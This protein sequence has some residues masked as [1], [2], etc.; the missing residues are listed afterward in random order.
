ME[1]IFKGKI[2]LKRSSRVFF[3]GF[4]IN[5]WRLVEDIVLYVNFLFINR[6]IV[7]L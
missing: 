4:R 3:C 2:V 6:D 1:F 5:G 7:I